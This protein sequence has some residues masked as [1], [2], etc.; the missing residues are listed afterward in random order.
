MYTI[1]SKRFGGALVAAGLVLGAP[2]CDSAEPGI[3]GDGDGEI[4]LRE[5]PWGTGRLN[6]NFLGEDESYPLN[7]LPL[8]DDPTADTRIHAVWTTRCVDRNLGVTY[9]NELFYTSDLDGDLGISVV[10]GAL[11]PATFKKFGDPTVTCSVSGNL[12]EKTVWGVITHDAVGDHN[13]YLMLIDRTLDENSF[14]TH[15]W[16][17]YTGQGSP[18]MDDS[19]TPTCD[20]DL[21]PNLEIGTLQ[22]HSYLVEDLDVDPISG[23]FSEVAD[24]FFIACRSGAVGKSVA[25]GYAPW[26]VGGAVHELATRAVRADYC[27]DGFSYTFEGNPIQVQDDFEINTYDNNLLTDEAAWDLETGAATCVTMPREAIYQNGF[28]AIACEGG[29]VTLPAC[30]SGLLGAAEITT[31]LAQ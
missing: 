27:G 10:D 20:E 9:Q 22:Y 23:D 21:D 16:G 5:D 14:P 13:H 28:V 24:Q 1:S 2:G 31:K 6:T 17:V 26:E 30:D 8:V 15:L 12:W 7:A 18:F 29:E 4:S 19:Y 3:D 11:Q 25:W